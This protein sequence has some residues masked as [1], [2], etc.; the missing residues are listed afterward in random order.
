M[1]R[2]KARKNV[3]NRAFMDPNARTVRCECGKRLALLWPAEV[4]RRAQP[5]EGVGGTYFDW[6]RVTHGTKH[7]SSPAIKDLGNEDWMSI[8][9]PRCGKD[10]Q[11]REG[12]LCEL[13]R[14][15]AP[16]ESVTLGTT[17][18]PLWI[19]RTSLTW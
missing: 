19:R 10:W 6:S 8:R 7:A 13:I 15:V 17:P 12:Y 2:S 3:A 9:C 18:R 5:A 1:P 16:G 11:G 4:Y 14:G